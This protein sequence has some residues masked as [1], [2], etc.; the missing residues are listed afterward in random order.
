MILSFV[1]TLN[2]SAENDTQ[3]K[4]VVTEIPQRIA[5]FQYFKNNG[6]F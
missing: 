1:L 5:L 6:N 3:N 4:H 2:Y